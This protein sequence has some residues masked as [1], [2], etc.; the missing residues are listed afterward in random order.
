MA[1]LTDLPSETLLRILAFNVPVDKQPGPLPELQK[2]LKQ[3]TISSQLSP[4][5]T[6]A[7]VTNFVAYVETSTGPRMEHGKPFFPAFGRT[8]NNEEIR[9]A[10][11][12][13]HLDITDLGWLDDRLRVPFREHVMKLVCSFKSLRSVKVEAAQSDS[14]EDVLRAICQDLGRIV[15]DSTGEMTG[16]EILIV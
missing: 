11:Q 2:Y 8:L 16:V 15:V 6:E 5:V 7:F 4:I 10:V 14:K 12:T 1:K 9:D 13:L 3:R